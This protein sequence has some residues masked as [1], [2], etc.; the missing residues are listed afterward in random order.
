MDHDELL[1]RHL[2]FCKRMFERM[3][4]EGSWPWTD[5]QNS[6]DLVESKEVKQ[7]L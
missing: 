5:S 7:D 4:A 2:E 1:E 3:E 6:E